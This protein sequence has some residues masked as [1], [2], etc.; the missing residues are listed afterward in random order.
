MLILFIIKL[1]IR[2]WFIVKRSIKEV[3]FY[4]SVKG[5]K[6]PKTKY[7]IVFNAKLDQMRLPMLY[8]AVNWDPSQFHFLI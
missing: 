7:P 4:I 1:I 8:S 2:H 6:S 5:N 3:P